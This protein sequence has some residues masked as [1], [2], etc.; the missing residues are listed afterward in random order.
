MVFQAHRQAR[1]E[2]ATLRCKSCQGLL[3]GH[4][5]VLD[6]QW[7]HGRSTFD[8]ILGFPGQIVRGTC[9]HLASVCFSVSYV[10]DARILCHLL[11][12]VAGRTAVFTR[13]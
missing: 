3:D 10:L 9:C 11:G 7:S 12:L 13:S 4:L 1:L 6:D 5:L 8:L 2:D